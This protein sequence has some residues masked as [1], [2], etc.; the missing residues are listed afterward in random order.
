MRRILGNVVVFSLLS[1]AA[2]FAQ[3]PAE[4]PRPETKTPAERP[5]SELRAPQKPE[6]PSQDRASGSAAHAQPLNVKLDLTISDQVGPGE[7]AKRTVSMIV[8]DRTKGS[9]RSTGNQVQARMFVDAMPRVL[10]NGD[11][12]VY[13][14]LDYNPRQAVTEKGAQSEFPGTEARNPIGGSSL[15]QTMT[16]IVQPGKPLVISQAADPVSDR[17]ITVEVRATILK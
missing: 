6:P 16:V 1:G 5:R 11:V 14:G 9:I 13:L 2:A 3:T 4:K 7:P 15:N 10:A 17:K 12:E 8:A